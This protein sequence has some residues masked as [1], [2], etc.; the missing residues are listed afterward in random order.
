M[1]VTHAALREHYTSIAV[2]WLRMLI[3]AEAM[4]K[5][6]EEK[7]KDASPVKAEKKAGASE[8]EEEEEEEEQEE[9]QSEKASGSVYTVDA[10]I[11]SLQEKKSGKPKAIK[12]PKDVKKQVPAKVVKTTNTN[13][14]ARKNV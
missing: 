9:E 12:I 8:D 4:E 6:E 5:E 2:N 7:S 14:F 13:K 10:Q 3:V 11:D 1:P